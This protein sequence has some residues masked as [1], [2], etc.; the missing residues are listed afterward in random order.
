MNASAQRF[1]HIASCLLVAAAVMSWSGAA[2]AQTS[3]TKDG[4]CAYTIHVPL[5]IYGPN[6]TPELAARWKRNI[7]AKWNGP[8]EEM[9]RKMYGGEGHKGI[10][11]PASRD[12]D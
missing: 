5:E 11:L 6:A 3:I 2:P 4:D 10:P 8:T 12:D 9:V 1:S 7:E